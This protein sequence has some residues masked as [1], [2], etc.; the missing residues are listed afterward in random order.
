MASTEDL[1]FTVTLYRD[2]AKIITFTMNYFLPH[3]Y[4]IIDNCFLPE[5]QT[6]YT[7]VE[8]VHRGKIILR[9]SL[10]NDAVVC[11]MGR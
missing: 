7:D 9:K 2:S 8:I 10:A 11:G 4:Q 6:F 3:A 1:N 5:G